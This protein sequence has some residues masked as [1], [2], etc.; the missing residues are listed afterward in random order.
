MVDPR[1]GRPQRVREGLRNR[2][3]FQ[4]SLQADVGG[5][6][7]MSAL[8]SQQL[9]DFIDRLQRGQMVA[10]GQGQ[11]EDPWQTARFSPVA[12]QPW[13]NAGGGLGR[14]HELGHEQTQHV[15]RDAP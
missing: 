6:A 14:E 2:E 5:A 12:S 3:G 8:E 4:A 11:P 1:L 15:F 10:T 13:N 7:H 9:V